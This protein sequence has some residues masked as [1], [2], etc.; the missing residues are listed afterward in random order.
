MWPPWQAQNNLEMFSLLLGYQNTETM[1][2]K[3]L[4]FPGVFGLQKEKA[5]AIPHILILCQTIW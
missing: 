4:E 1:A 3:T 2:S 5:E